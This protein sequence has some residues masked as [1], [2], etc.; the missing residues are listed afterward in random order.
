MQIHDFAEDRRPKNYAAQR[1][2][3]AGGRMATTLYP[4]APQVHY[5]ALTSRD[6][7]NLATL[8]V[9]EERCHLLANPV[10]GEPFTAKTTNDAPPTILYPT[11]A[12]RRKNLGE[13]LLLAAL[14]EGG[15]RWATTLRPENPAWQRIHAD[16]EAFAAELGLPVAFGLGEDPS[17]DFPSLIADARAI[18]TTSVAEGFGLAFLEPALWR[19]PLIGRDLPDITADFTS[20]GW[21]GQT[22]DP[23]MSPLYTSIPIPLDWL[24]LEALRETYAKDLAA[25]FAAYE[26][27]L[28]DADKVACWENLTASGQVDFGRLP[29]PLQAAVIR[30]IVANPTAKTALPRPAELLAAADALDAEAQAQVVTEHFNPAAYGTH[31]AALYRKIAASE[32]AAFTPGNAPALLDA[33]LDPR[34]ANALL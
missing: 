19:K 7:A 9:P 30:R 13:L 26:R 33:F 2:A 12:I 11:R 32:C 1:R 3:L 21:T 15:H 34:R 24:D 14:D 23:P 22:A 25:A 17:V 28:T 4:Q 16:W 29:E 31:L 6:L 5:A 10:V 27:R 20:V 8:G 18:V